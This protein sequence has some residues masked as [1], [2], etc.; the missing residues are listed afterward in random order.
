MAG[1]AVEGIM[2][3][4]ETLGAVDVARRMTAEHMDKIE[5]ILGNK[6]EGYQG[7]GAPAWFRS[8]QG[9]WAVT[10]ST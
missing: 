3:L 6:P 8:I 10:C 9:L 4:E 1:S 7:Y 5:T 2:T